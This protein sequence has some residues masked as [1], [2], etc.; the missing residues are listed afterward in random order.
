[1]LEDRLIRLEKKR[2]R[3]A[4]INRIREQGEGQL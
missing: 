3:K 4:I 1:M 2:L